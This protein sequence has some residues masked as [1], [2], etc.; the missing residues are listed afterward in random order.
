MFRYNQTKYP[1]PLVAER[2][3]Q[4]THK[5]RR[6]GNGVRH[7]RRQNFCTAQTTA[8]TSLDHLVGAGY[9]RWRHLEAER[10]RSLKIDNEFELGGLHDR[11]V[12]RLGAFEDWTGIDA[13]LTPHVRNIGPIAHQPAGFDLLASGIGR[14]NPVARRKRRKLNAPADEERVGCD[15]QGIG[16]VAH[17]GGECCLDL[18]AGASVEEL[19]LESHSA[20]SF[21]QL[22]Q[23]GLG[24]RHVARIDQ[25][26]HAN[27]LWRQLVQQTQSLGRDLHEEDVDAG[28]I[29]ARPGKARYQTELH[30]IFADPEHDRDCRGRGFGRARSNR[31]TGRGD[32]GYAAADEVG[33][34]RRQPVVLAAEPVVLHRHV[35]AFDVAGFAEAFA[36]GGYPVRCRLARP[37]ID[38]ANDRNGGLLHLRCDRPRRRRAAEQRDE[39]AARNHSMTSSARASRDG[40]TSRPSAFAV[41]RLITSW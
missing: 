32:Y 9:Q 8:S 26:G 24:A 7:A 22:S 41:L 2:S 39:L 19:N 27:G 33:H 5:Y 37:R 11:Q 34:Q 17:E 36:E 38:K 1:W 20:S 15:K 30:S 12:G 31:A 16:P 3:A 28:R 23:S 10:S 25:H 13:D 6:A 35:L 40:G 14:G 4:S 18:A 29:A 21:G